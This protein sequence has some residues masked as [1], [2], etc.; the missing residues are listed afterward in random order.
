ML[1]LLFWSRACG[2]GGGRKF[3]DDEEEK[4]WRRERGVSRVVGSL[5]IVH[6][7]IH[8]Y[9]RAHTRTHTHEQA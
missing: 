7:H 1:L 9:K 5:M 2:I 4:E 8:L 3:I 6:T